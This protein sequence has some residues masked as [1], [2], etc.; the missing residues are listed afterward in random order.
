MIIKRSP[1]SVDDN[2]NRKRISIEQ[3]I[4]PPLK[5]SESSISWYSHDR[6][7]SRLLNPPTRAED[8]TRICIILG[9][10]GLFFITRP[11]HL[12]FKSIKAILFWSKVYLKGEVHKSS[13]QIFKHGLKHSFIICKMIKYIIICKTGIFKQGLKQGLKHSFIICKTR[14]I[15]GVIGLYILIDLEI[16]IVFINPSKICKSRGFPSDLSLCIFN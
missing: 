5:W 7:N 2:E 3:R 16:Y 1:A 6:S 8:I 13:F 4:L 11:K 15:G 14:S 9:S 12:L 10:R